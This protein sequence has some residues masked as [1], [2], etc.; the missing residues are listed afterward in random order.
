MVELNSAQQRFSSPRS[1]WMNL[2][3]KSMRAQSSRLGVSDRD[4]GLTLL[5]CLVAMIVISLVVALITPPIFLAVGTR[6]NNRRTEQALQVAQE[7]IERVRLLM[8]GGEAYDTIKDQLPLEA[9]GVTRTTLGKAAVPTA[10]CNTT[11]QAGP[12]PLC[13]SASS[14][15]LAFGTSKDDPSALFVQTFRDAGVSNPRPSP[16]GTT[17]PD[18]EIIAFNMGVRVYSHEALNAAK[19]GVGTLDTSGQAAAVGFTTGSKSRGSRPLVVLYTEVARG[20]Q[21]G[22]LVKMKEY[23][24]TP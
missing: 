5:E 22:A 11:T 13:N 2:L 24:G 9:A 12:P 17:I 14:L 1:L 18:P 23:T 20:T 15:F 10:L 7:E 3:S 8:I 19:T 4:T 16:D 6:V 21:A